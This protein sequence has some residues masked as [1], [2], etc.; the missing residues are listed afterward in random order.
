MMRALFFVVAALAA[1]YGGYW[2]VG[3]RRVEGGLRQALADL[4]ADGWEVDYASLD[5][6]GFPSR[7]DTTITGLRL[8]D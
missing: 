1:L 5:T 4:A 2:F 3:E 7:F 8:G 6:T